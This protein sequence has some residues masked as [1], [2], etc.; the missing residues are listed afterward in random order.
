MRVIAMHI[1]ISTCEYFLYLK[2]KY[3]TGIKEISKYL[4]TSVSFLKEMT[5]PP[6]FLAFFENRS[7]ENFETI[8]L[9]E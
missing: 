5:L 4:K 1:S 3:L 7:S 9:S 2:I 6:P 8:D